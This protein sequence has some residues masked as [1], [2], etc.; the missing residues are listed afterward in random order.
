[1]WLK[2]KPQMDLIFLELGQKK[3]LIYLEELTG[4]SK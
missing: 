4:K 2:S 1:M 3:N